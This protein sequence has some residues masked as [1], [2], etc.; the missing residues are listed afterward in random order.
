MAFPPTQWAGKA[1]AVSFSQDSGFYDEGFY[2]T[3]S[4]DV[5]EIYYTLDCSAPDTNS[6]HYTGPIWIQDASPNE[7]QLKSFSNLVQNEENY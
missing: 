4:S 7:N 1:E 2:L 5:G 3:L 6:I